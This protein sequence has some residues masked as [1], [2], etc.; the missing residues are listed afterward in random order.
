[1]RAAS[2]PLLPAAIRSPSVPRASTLRSQSRRGSRLCAHLAVLLEGLEIYILANTTVLTFWHIHKST[3][4]YGRGRTRQCFS[5]AWK[6]AQ[7]W[8]RYLASP[9]VRHSTNSAST[10][11]GRSRLCAAPGDMSSPLN[12]TSSGAS[13]AGA[14]KQ[15]FCFGIAKVK[16]L[17]NIP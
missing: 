9:V 14:Q 6:M 5:K 11:S 17:R 16:I 15:F 13:P 7:P 4:D 8:R 2:A 12:I 1:M 10:V 3:S